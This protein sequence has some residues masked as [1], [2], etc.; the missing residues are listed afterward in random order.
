MGT[1]RTC[2]S[3]AA[4]IV[5]QLAYGGSNIL[6]KIA[7]DKGISQLVF[8]LYR[9]IIAMFVLGPLAFAFER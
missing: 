1:A 5:V 2:S 3:Y 4:M 7:L 9:H 8:I 6:I